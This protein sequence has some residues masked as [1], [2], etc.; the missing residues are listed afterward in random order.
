M[1]GMVAQIDEQSE[2]KHKSRVLGIV[3]NVKRVGIRY[4]E[5]FFV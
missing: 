4:F 1:S 5:E 2:R 3:G